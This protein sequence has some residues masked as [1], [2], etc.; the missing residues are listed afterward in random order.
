MLRR[1]LRLLCSGAHGAAAAT[2][3][4]ASAVASD[5]SLVASAFVPTKLALFLPPGW[6]VE[7]AAAG[8]SF[9]NT[10]VPVAGQPPKSAS[11]EAQTPRPPQRQLVK[12]FHFGEFA[13]MYQ[14]VGRCAGLGARLGCH[15]T[16]EWFYLGIVVR[17]PV[18]P[19]GETLALYMNDGEATRAMRRNTT[20]GTGSGFCNW[21]ADVTA[22]LESETTENFCWLL[23]KDKRQLNAFIQET[24]MQWFHR[25]D[26]LV[27]RKSRQKKD[28]RDNLTLEQVMADSM[29]RKRRLERRDARAKEHAAR[30]KTADGEDAPF[31]ADV[32]PR[33]VRE[34]MDAE[35]DGMEDARFRS[36][37]PVHSF[38]LN[39]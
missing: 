8:A 22:A 11:S 18:S 24:Y 9:H 2:G 31:V 6:N 25:A 27:F 34:Q 36:G 26:Y 29:Q 16:F 20:T 33:E 21:D 35:H 39:H 38:R 7:N 14:W 13:Q 37:N 15:P 23:T 3:A 32:L 1:G 5:S 17:L 28:F 12:Q 19:E 4:A 10:H 30:P